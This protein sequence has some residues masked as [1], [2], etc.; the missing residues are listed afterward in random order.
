MGRPTKCTPE[1]TKKI[2][3]LIRKGST[4][5]SACLQVGITRGMYYKWRV[6]GEKGQAPFEAF[7][8]DVDQADAVAQGTMAQKLFNGDPAWRA[9]IRFLERRDPEG[10]ARRKPRALERPGRIHVTFNV[11]EPREASPKADG[12]ALRAIRR[13]PPAAAPE[14][15]ESAQA[16]APSGV[17]SVPRRS[18]ARMQ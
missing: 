6:L 2:C 15:L 4:I 11:P 17:R 8:D 7:F 3:E 9:A 1:L 18:P 12:Q 14:R 10:W 16:L 13:C 5:V